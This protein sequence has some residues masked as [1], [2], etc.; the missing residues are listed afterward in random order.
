ML[1]SSNAIWAWIQAFRIRLAVR[2]AWSWRPVGL[3]IITRNQA[4]AIGPDRSGSPAG[5][6]GIW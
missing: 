3:V 4:R 1:V 5:I 2:R 6:P